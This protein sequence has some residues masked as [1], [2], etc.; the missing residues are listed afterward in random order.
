MTEKFTKDEIDSLRNE[1][2]NG[3]M[4]VSMNQNI[5]D[6]AKT[7]AEIKEHG[8]SQD[9]RFERIESDVNVL[10]EGYKKCSAR[11]SNKENKIVR[12]KVKRVWLLCVSV[13]SAVGALIAYLKGLF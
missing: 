8:I 9:L 4:L 2:T 3:R 5:L 10:K 7:T 12:K 13:V 1:S 11:L 6:I